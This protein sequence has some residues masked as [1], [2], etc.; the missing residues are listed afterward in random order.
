MPA[1]TPVVRD[2]RKSPAL[3]YGVAIFLSAFLLFQVQPLIAKIILPWF[4][5]AAA[6]W[7]VCLLFFQVMLLLGYFYALALTRWAPTRV[8]GSV[9]ALVVASSLLV[10][11]ILPKS[12]WT[13]SGPD[14]PIRHILLILG[15]TVGLPY[16]SLSS[17]SPLLQAWYSR[18][19]PGGTPYRF[20]ALSNAGSILALLTYPF[21][22]EPIFSSS[23]QATGWS[24]AYACVASL[25][26]V[27]GFLGP[28]EVPLS[29]NRRQLLPRE[30]G[31]H[32]RSG[33]RL[34]HAGP[35]CSFQ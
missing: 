20:Y 22:V 30:I 5:G 18:T 4:G 35:L 1:A 19:H 11:P 8:Q 16:F 21:L 28:G 26:A 10:L 14:A 29:P 27:V 23:H 31:R 7:V 32:K 33:S 2:V 25:C 9:H 3:L 17:T 24:V 6:V 12:S 34:R 15:A 13:P